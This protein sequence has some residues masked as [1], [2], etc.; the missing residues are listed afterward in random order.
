MLILPFFVPMGSGGAD[1]PWQVKVWLVSLVALS[2]AM[3]GM[4]ALS[5]ISKQARDF[6]LYPGDAGWVLIGYGLLWN[7]FALPLVLLVIT[8]IQRLRRK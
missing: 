8:G 5:M 1:M 4:G 3:L 2:L 6:F 7:F